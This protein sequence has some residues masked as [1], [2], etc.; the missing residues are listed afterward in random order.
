MALVRCSLHPVDKILAKNNYVTRAK[1]FGSSNLGVICGRTRCK[2][3]G[4]VW[5]TE[6]ELEEFHKGNRIFSLANRGVK[7]KVS[8]ELIPLP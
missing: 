5:L 8:D 1:L 3:T 7:L 6:K 4:L 2:N